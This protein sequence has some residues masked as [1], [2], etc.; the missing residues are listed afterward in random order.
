MKK[1]NKIIASLLVMVLALMSPMSVYAM[2]QQNIIA[3]QALKKQL[4]ADKRQYCKWGRNQIKYAYADVDGDNVLELITEPGYGYLTQA[5]YDYQNGTVRNVASVGQE[6]FSCQC[7]FIDRKF[8]E[9]YNGI[10]I[11]ES[12]E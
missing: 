5:V 8:S 10:Y 11:N 6:Y 3:Q 9:H 7:G 12:E 4:I 1:S 2:S